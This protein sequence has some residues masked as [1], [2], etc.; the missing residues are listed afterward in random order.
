MQMILGGVKKKEIKLGVG[1][2]HIKE[3]GLNIDVLGTNSITLFI[4]NDAINELVMC[5]FQRYKMI[6]KCLISLFAVLIMKTKMLYYS[7]VE[8]YLHTMDYFDSAAF[9]HARSP[10][11]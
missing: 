9:S 7:I 4:S 3:Y 11:N 10:D 8:C 5:S 6:R 1:I 2:K